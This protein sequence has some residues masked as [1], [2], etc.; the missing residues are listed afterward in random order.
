MSRSGSSLSRWR[1]WA[2]TRLAM[3]SSMG[4]PRVQGRRRGSRDRRWSVLWSVWEADVVDRWDGSGSIRLASFTRDLH[5]MVVHF[6]VALLLTG[7]ALELVAAVRGNADRKIT[8]LNSSR[9]TISYAVFCLK[10]KKKHKAKS[11][12]KTQQQHPQQ[13]EPLHTRR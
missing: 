12:Q 8:R 11:A 5:P 10:K 13:P 4:V 2:M 9:I 3:V 1:S 6:P 7:L